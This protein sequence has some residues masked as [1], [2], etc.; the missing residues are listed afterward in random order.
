MFLDGKPVRKSASESF[1]KALAR[2]RHL[3]GMKPKDGGED[4]KHEQIG[5]HLAKAHEALT[6]AKE[7]HEGGTPQEG[8]EGSHEQGEQESALGG[9]G[10]S[11]DEG[12]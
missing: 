8:E 12:V 3:E 4:D 9:L 11:Q 2:H 5:H 10:I 1:G 6:A 7:L